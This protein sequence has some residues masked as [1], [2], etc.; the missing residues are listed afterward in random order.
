MFKNTDDLEKF[1]ERFEKSELTYLYLEYDNFKLKLDKRMSPSESSGAVEVA[2]SADIGGEYVTSPLVGIFYA[3]AGGKAIAPVG[4]KV[5]K[6]QPVCT[7]EAMK[8]M[9]D[10]PS[11]CD[12][13]VKE[14]LVSD[15]KMVE[16]GQKLIVI[17]KL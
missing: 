12:G 15:G 4:T 3:S 5:K 14:I 17:E 10:I 16:F 8:M 1:V 11:P 7:V 9:N 6:G 2:A 13:V